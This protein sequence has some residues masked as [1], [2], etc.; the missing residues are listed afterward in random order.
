MNLFSYVMIISL[1][2]FLAS[3]FLAILDWPTTSAARVSVCVCVSLFECAYAQLP[4]SPSK[5]LFSFH[6]IIIDRTVSISGFLTIW[7]H[8]IANNRNSS[9]LT[10]SPLM[11]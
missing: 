4:K 5:T 6:V 11:F 7:S 1:T 10:N 9:T 8:G 2:I 3:V